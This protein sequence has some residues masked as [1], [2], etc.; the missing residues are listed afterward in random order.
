MLVLTASVNIPAVMLSHKCE[1][2]FTLAYRTID[3]SFNFADG[4]ATHDVIEWSAFFSK[5]TSILANKKSE[6]CF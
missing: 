2:G 4:I 5:R 6:S 3:F 1:P